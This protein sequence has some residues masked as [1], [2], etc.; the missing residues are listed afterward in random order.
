MIAYNKTLAEIQA[1]EERLAAE[2]VYQEALTTLE[3][4]QADIMAGRGGSVSPR[5]KPHLRPRRFGPATQRMPYV[6]SV[7]R[8]KRPGMNTTMRSS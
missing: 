5:C 6:S 4:A 1:E 8:S 7:V 3:S 2:P